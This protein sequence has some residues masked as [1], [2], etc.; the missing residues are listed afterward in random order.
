MVMLEDGGERQE[1]LEP[2]SEDSGQALQQEPVRRNEPSSLERNR[3]RRLLTK[4]G[5]NQGLPRGG[6]TA[7][8]TGTEEKTG[9]NLSTE[10]ESDPSP[11]CRT[12]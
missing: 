10:T 7:G 12:K 3:L 4:V 11:L 8:V 1:D 9:F 2:S 5:T 6:G